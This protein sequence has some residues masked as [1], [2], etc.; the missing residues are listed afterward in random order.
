VQRAR[1]QESRARVTATERR[2]DLLKLQHVTQELNAT[3]NELEEFKRKQEQ[4]RNEQFEIMHRQYLAAVN[5]TEKRLAE[6]GQRSEQCE[7]ELV[8]QILAFEN[9]VGRLKEDNQTLASR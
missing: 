9:E 8:D 7:N 5:D 1:Y 3:K 6:S 4:W 2:K